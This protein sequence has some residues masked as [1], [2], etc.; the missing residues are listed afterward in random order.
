MIETQE[1]LT[2][3]ERLRVLGLFSLDKKKAQEN[4]I[5]KYKFL[6]GNGKEDGARHFSEVGAR[7]NIC[8]KQKILFKHKKTTGCGFV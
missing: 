6:I 8:R 1:H 2:H 3:E 7:D 5:N 4:L